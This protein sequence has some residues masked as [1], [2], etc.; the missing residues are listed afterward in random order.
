MSKDVQLQK[1]VR[2]KQEAR[3]IA[4]E[5]LNFGVT[6]DQKFDIMF[7]IALSLENNDALKEITSV[8]K[9]YKSTINNEEDDNNFIENEHKILTS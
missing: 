4:R 9:K 3:N 6:E 5:V 2:L 7:Q 8:L 1:S